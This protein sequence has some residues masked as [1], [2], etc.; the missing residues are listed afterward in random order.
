M[1]LGPTAIRLLAPAKETLPG[2]AKLPLRERVRGLTDP[3]DSPRAGKYCATP[4]AQG[5]GLT[6]VLLKVLE[7]TQA[8]PKWA[9]GSPLLAKTKVP[10][11]SRSAAPA[12]AFVAVAE[13]VS[14]PRA[15]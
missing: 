11:P 1:S 13:V 2:S 15:W 5:N 14:V 7:T 4:P 12:P 3:K 10:V 8:R 9:T 6:P